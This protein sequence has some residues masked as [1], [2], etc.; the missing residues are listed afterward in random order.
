VRSDLAHAPAASTGQHQQHSPAVSA[1]GLIGR[2]RTWFT[3]YVSRI[4][5]FCI[6][7]VEKLRHD[8][9]E[10]VT[11]AIQPAHVHARNEFYDRLDGPL[12]RAMT[13]VGQRKQ[14]D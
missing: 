3:W 13:F 6:V 11:R 10:L 8:R 7:E 2:S 5:A 1:D 12:L 14:V 4:L 9:S